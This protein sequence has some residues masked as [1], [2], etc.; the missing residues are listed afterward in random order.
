V[1]F[2]PNTL[3]VPIHQKGKEKRKEKKINLYFPIHLTNPKKMSFLILRKSFRSSKIS[4]PTPRISFLFS[5]A[6]HKTTETPSGS[7]R[8]S[9]SIA[10]NPSSTPGYPIYRH[11]FSGIYSNSLPSIK[12]SNGFHQTPFLSTPAE[13]E[14][15]IS[16]SGSPIFRRN[17]SVFC[18]NLLP[19]IKNLCQFRQSLV[20]LT[21][22]RYFG[23]EATVQP[24][25][26]DGL[27]VEGIIASNWT[28]LDESESDWKS[29]AAAIAQSIHLIKKRLR[30]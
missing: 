29:H 18:P 30:V 10:E 3:N 1:G 27:T 24:S 26:A 11:S 2:I 19:S 8:F 21:P 7:R 22:F 9:H 6:S 25:T 28:I 12:N 15:L 20:I 5:Y 4:T 16:G 14:K 23:T 13:S 17:F